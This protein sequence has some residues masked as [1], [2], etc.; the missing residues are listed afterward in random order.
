MRLQD[1][2]SQAR[3]DITNGTFTVQS[4]DG[5]SDDGQGT[6]EAVC[7]GDTAIRVEPRC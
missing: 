3:P 2:L 1:F 6:T 7:C 5:G 4:V